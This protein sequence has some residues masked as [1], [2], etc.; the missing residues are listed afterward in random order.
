MTTAIIA[1]R[2]PLFADAVIIIHSSEGSHPSNA[3]RAL[4]STSFAVVFGTA[5]ATAGFATI[6]PQKG[7]ESMSVGVAHL[8]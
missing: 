7:P 6:T 1:F 2:S 5:L 8:S 3:A 4:T